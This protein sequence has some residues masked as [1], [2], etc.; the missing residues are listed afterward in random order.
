MDYVN[1]KES[2]K[3]YKLPNKKL[4]FIHVNALIILHNHIQ[5]SLDDTE[6]GGFLLGYENKNTGSIIID[7]LTI[8]QKKDKRFRNRFLLKDKNH[9]RLIKE[10]AKK[11]SYFLGTWHTHP[12]DYVSPSLLDKYDWKKSIWKESPAATF[13]LFIIIGRKEI[14]VWVGETKTKKIKRIKEVY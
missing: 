14:G 10:A 8:P 5:S 12:T 9:I 2:L 7:N 11:E 1:R 3:K 4:L 6:A 13:M